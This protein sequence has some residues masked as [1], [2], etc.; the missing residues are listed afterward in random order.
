M[1]IC[2]HVGNQTDDLS[3]Q[4]EMIWLTEIILSYD[5]KSIFIN[6]INELNDQ[7]S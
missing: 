1:Q 4:N 7:A 5:Y 3:K 6:C 2:M